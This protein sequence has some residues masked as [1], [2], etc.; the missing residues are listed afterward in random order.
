MPLRHRRDPGGIALITR[1][2]EVSI[3]RTPGARDRYSPYRGAEVLLRPRSTPRSSAVTISSTGFDLWSP[4]LTSSRSALSTGCIVRRI[5]V[6]RAGMRG[7][8]IGNIWQ[9]NTLALPC[10]A[11]TGWC[12][13][14]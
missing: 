3:G 10:P 14:R 4:V 6:G 1:S 13:G 9:A 5:Q 12:V 8:G 11:G 2:I 7:H